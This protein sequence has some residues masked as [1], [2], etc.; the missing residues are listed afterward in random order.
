MSAKRGFA[1]AEASIAIDLT[2]VIDGD[3][4]T[5]ST[6][7]PAG[8]TV[9]AV[10]VVPPF[11]P[12]SAMDDA[13]FLRIVEDAEEESRRF[14]DDDSTGVVVA[15]VDTAAQTDGGV[16]GLRKRWVLGEPAA[17]QDLP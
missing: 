3:L 6:I 16:R 11:E 12:L 10:G 2:A 14:G 5:A 7:G 4:T 8:L 15:V 1:V 9:D 17:E 13:E